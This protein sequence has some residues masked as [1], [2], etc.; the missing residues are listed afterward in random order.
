MMRLT[1]TFEF[2]LVGV[3]LRSW[4]IYIKLGEILATVYSAV[5]S[6]P[7]RLW[8]AQ[9]AHAGTLVGGTQV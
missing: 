8:D 1:V 3:F 6:T 2:I 5:L 7:S 9:G 4:M